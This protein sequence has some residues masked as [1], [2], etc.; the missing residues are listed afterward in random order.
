MYLYFYGVDR[1]W[2]FPPKLDNDVFWDTFS[3]LKNSDHP[4]LLEVI[5][6][7]FFSNVIAF[8]FKIINANIFLESYSK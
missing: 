6:R 5:D 7:F 4:K 2:G 1:I 8:F 3:L